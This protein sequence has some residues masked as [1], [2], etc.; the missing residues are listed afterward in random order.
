MNLARRVNMGLA[1]HQNH[2]PISVGQKNRTILTLAKLKRLNGI[3]IS[4]QQALA[5]LI[6]HQKDFTQVL[7]RRRRTA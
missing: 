6:L 2:D 7:L 4:F 3:D 1:P 5:V